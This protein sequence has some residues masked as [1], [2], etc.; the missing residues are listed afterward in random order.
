VEHTAYQ[1]LWHQRLNRIFELAGFL[2]QPRP[3]LTDHKRNLKSSGA[4]T[5]PAVRKTSGKWGR[6][7]KLV[8]F[9]TRTSTQ[10]LALAKPLGRSKKFAVK[11]CGLDVA[12]KASVARIN[13][14][15][16]KPKRALNLFGS[17]SSA[18]N[19]ESAPSQR[20]WKRPRESSILKQV[21]KPPPTKGMFG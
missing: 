18:S 13:V 12:E 14:A 20:L 6:G 21:T 10:E 17:D 19:D 1:G 2:C 15:G 11:S 7:R 8:R 4:V 5:A 9:E 3:E 16:G